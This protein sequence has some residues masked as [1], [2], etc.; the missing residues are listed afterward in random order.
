[1][2]TMQNREKIEEKIK[3]LEE[4]NPKNIT[5]FKIIEQ[6]IKS[7]LKRLNSS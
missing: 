5:E 4:I 6:E 1:M 7:L 2:N 3:E